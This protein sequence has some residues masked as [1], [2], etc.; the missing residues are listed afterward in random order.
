MENIGLIEKYHISKVDGTPIDEKAR[1][2]VLRY[3]PYQEDS[4][5]MFACRKALMK[6][7]DEI[8]NH[9]P[10]LAEDIRNVIHDSAVYTK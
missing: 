8:E 6:Y 5:H 4:E 7:A 9:L 1:Y 10:K 3:D 2:F